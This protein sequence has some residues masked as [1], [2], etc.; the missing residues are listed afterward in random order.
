MSSNIT[1]LTKYTNGKL[2]KVIILGSLTA[3][4]TACGTSTDPN[5]YTGYPVTLSGYAGN[6]NTSV[7]YT[8]QIAR[9]VLHD[10]LKSLSGKGSGNDNPNLKSEEIRKIPFHFHL[11]GN[12]HPCYFQFLSFYQNQQE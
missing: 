11:S 1:V 7:S 12:L 6:K 5:V 8:G 10:S 2:G 9:H 4:A 3:L